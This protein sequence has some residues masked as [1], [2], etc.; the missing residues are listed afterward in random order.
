MM[1]RAA[2]LRIETLAMT[3]RAKRSLDLV[4]PHR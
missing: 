1:Q 3:S 2:N 4:V